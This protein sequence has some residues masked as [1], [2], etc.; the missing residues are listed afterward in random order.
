MDTTVLYKYLDASGGLAMLENHNLKFTNATK[1][2][3]PFDCHPA[4]FDYS[5]PNISI[6]EEDEDLSPSEYFADK[7]F[8]DMDTLRNSTWICSLSKEY[9]S[10]LM[11]SYYNKHTGICVGINM[12]K[13]RP[14]LSSLVYPPLLGVKELIVNYDE[15]INKYRY[16]DGKKD[17]WGYQVS[18][19][20]KA[21]E[22][23]QEIRLAFLNLSVGFQYKNKNDSRNRKISSLLKKPFFSVIEPDYFESVYLGVNILA[24]NKNKIIKVAKNLNPYIKIYQMT[25]DS[26]A[27]RLKEKLL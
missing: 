14:N 10:L 11:W 19:K 5:V 7:D 9:N 21:W 13:L 23:E 22:H 20:A 16:F 26:E 15:L 6:R 25:I 1:F 2:N 4:L 3:D 27:F 12:E 17:Y 8:F 18:T 24:R